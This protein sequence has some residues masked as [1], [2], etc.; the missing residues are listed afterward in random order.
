MTGPTHTLNTD[1]ACRGN[2]GEGGAGAVLADPAGRPVASL[3][4][5]LGSCTNNVAEYR[6][7][8]LGLAEAVRRGILRLDIRLD[9]ELVVRQ[10]EGTYRVRDAKLKP[11]LAEVR[12]LLGCLA[13]YTV[14]HVPREQNRLADDLANEALD[15]G[16]RAGA[17]GEAPQRSG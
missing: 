3:Q 11:L 14:R 9:S 1:G 15:A 2:P 12:R 6:A 10:I 17:G 16:L 7:L 4:A 8:I 13:G 5:Y